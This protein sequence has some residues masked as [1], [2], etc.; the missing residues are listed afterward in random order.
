VVAAILALMARMGWPWRIWRLLGLLS[1]LLVFLLGG[2]LVSVKIGGGN[3]IHN[4]DAFLT[5]VMVIAS[6]LVF[7]RFAPDRVIEANAPGIPG[8]AIALAAGIPILITLPFQSFRP[9][10]NVGPASHH[11]LAELQQIIDDTQR[12]H[13]GEILFLSE[14]QL[15]TFDTIHGVKLV[16]DYEKWFLMEMA[17]GGN[18][19]YFDNFDRDLANHRFALIV[20]EPINTY[21]QD[22]GNFFGEENDAWVKW[23][24]EPILENYTS[25]KEYDGEKIEIFIPKPK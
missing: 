5:L 11:G 12:D 21:D 10:P 19:E 9:V 17:M 1:V 7:G 16:P 25:I 13:P 8:W 6:Y 14:R 18:R 3:N 15:L 23:V 22:E 20:S 4:L 2:L 24:S